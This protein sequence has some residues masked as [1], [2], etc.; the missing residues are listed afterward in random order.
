MGRGPVSRWWKVCTYAI[1]LLYTSFCLIPLLW[2]FATSLK[3]KSEAVSFPPTLIPHSL[4]LENFL[5][6]FRSR[7]FG[8]YPFLNSALYALAGVVITLFVTTLSGFAFSRF[9]FKGRYLWFLLILFL[10]MMPGVAKL[11]PLY[12]MYVRYGLYDTRLGII[13]IFGISLIPMGTW[14][15]KGYFDRIPR[16]LEECAQIDGTSRLGA[17]WRVTFPLAAPGL[18][19]LA[20][21]TFMDAWNHFTY[22]LILLGKQNL[23][24][25][26]VAIYSFVGDYGR[27]EWHI[28][29]AVSVISVLPLVALFI[30]FQRALVSG[31][32]GGA[33]KG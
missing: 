18:G 12:L 17:L 23:L 20:V 11:V 3:S 27:V 5:V 32:T 33:I 10:D 8:P 28:V 21:I 29:S 19:A 24:P 6:P 16:E 15:M 31:L 7:S 9:R 25:Y 2:V 4:H 1:L 26:T 13:L 14:I 30:V 22:P